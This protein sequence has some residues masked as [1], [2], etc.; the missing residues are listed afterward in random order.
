MTAYFDNLVKALDL[1]AREAG[2][3][4]VVGMVFGHVNNSLAASP[5]NG[6]FADLTNTYQRYED[7]APTFFLGDPASTR[8]TAPSA[9]PTLA[10]PTPTT[11]APSPPPGR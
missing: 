4:T 3:D 6:A 5:H 9:S 11:R 7:F 10:R 2:D 8:T 1:I